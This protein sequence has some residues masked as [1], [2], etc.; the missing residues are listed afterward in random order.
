M[1]DTPPEFQDDG[2]PD[3]AFDDGDT[4]IV[5]DDRV[6]ELQARMDAVT[7]RESALA[8]YDDLAGGER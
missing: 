2:H 3:D 1:T 8:F 5:L 4:P 6:H 7:D